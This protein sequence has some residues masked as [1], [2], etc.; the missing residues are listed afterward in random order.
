MTLTLTLAIVQVEITSRVVKSN[1]MYIVD[2][3]E[4]ETASRANHGFCCNRS[5]RYRACE[6]THPIISDLTR[7]SR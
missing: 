1:R 4:F 7:P 2:R 3:F 6:N 5:H